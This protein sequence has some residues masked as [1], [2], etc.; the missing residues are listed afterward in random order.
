MMSFFQQLDC[1]F[2]VPL[3]PSFTFGENWLFKKY[4]PNQMGT[5]LRKIQDFLLGTTRSPIFL[6]STYLTGRGSFQYD[7]GLL[8]YRIPITIVSKFLVL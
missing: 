7:H 1:F 5:R 3:V 4:F 2:S 8:P 6:M